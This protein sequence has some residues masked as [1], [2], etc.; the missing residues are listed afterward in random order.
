M[1]IRNSR[2]NKL[3]AV[4]TLHVNNKINEILVDILCKL[5]PIS[6]MKNNKEDL[7]M[8]MALILSDDINFNAGPV[9]RKR[10][11]QRKDH[12]LEISNGKGLCFIHLH[13]YSLLPKTNKTAQ[14]C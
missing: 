2:K 14:N 8:K 5:L 10:K 3:F 1:N 12:K 4:I 13:I 11:D 6:K 9:T 7:Y